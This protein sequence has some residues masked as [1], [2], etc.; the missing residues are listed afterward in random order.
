MRKRMPS[1][2][3]AAANIFTYIHQLYIMSYNTETFE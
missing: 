2:N 1:H 3:A